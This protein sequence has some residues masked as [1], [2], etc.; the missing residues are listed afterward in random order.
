MDKLLVERKCSC[1]LC[2]AKIGLNSV[3]WS[4]RSLL[5]PSL[6]KNIPDA[7]LSQSYKQAIKLVRKSRIDRQLQDMPNLAYWA[8]CYGVLVWGIRHSKSY[9]S[10]SWKVW[11]FRMQL[12]R[13]TW[14]LNTTTPQNDCKSLC[15]ELASFWKQTATELWSK[16]TCRIISCSYSKHCISHCCSVCLAYYFAFFTVKSNLKKLFTLSLRCK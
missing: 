15:K 9:N 13:R 1:Y 4:G 12:Q 7:T 5:E 16:W 2:M 6:K 10:A 14:K 11:K 8:G 3:N